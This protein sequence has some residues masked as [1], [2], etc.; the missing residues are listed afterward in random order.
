MNAEMTSITLALRVFATLVFALLVD[1]PVSFAGSIEVVAIRHGESINNILS[2]KKQPITF[3]LEIYKQREAMKKTGSIVHNPVLSTEGRDGA[4][5]LNA[6]LF[7]NNQDRNG[8]LHPTSAKNPV[9]FYV[10]PLNRTIQ[11][12]ALVFKDQLFKAGVN[13]LA[14]PNVTEHRKSV[15]ED[16][17]EKAERPIQ[18]FETELQSVVNKSELPKMETWKNEFVSS[19]RSCCDNKIW[20]PQGSTESEASLSKRIEEFKKQLR[21]LPDNTRV[22]VVSHGTF[23]R[24]LFYGIKELSEKKY[25][26]RNLGILSGKLDKETG[27]WIG[28]PSCF[29]PH[30]N[31][32]ATSKAPDESCFDKIANLEGVE[33]DKG[34]VY[35]VSQLLPVLGSWQNRFLKIVDSEGFKG[36]TWSE[37][38]NGGV[39][40]G[41]AL[42]D[43]ETDECK[44]GI[45]EKYKQDR[46]TACYV[47]KRVHTDEHGVAWDKVS[48]TLEI[49]PIS[50]VKSNEQA[51]QYLRSILNAP[52]S[53]KAGASQEVKV[54]KLGPP[55][56]PN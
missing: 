8:L 49:L 16:G 43:S 50:W 15:S 38:H 32:S 22:I 13:M 47:I 51:T 9:V 56:K 34:P 14:N 6:F 20:W 27:K 39:L 44:K 45:P 48:D 17:F 7:P 41:A 31:H 40:K 4:L 33:I 19:M 12:A 18:L 54:E 10:S 26:L 55:R 25:H 23:L 11:T 35:S 53:P 46:E 1:A 52:T 2:Q 29:V 24:T 36:V 42:I 21:S 28:E 37:K 3:F 30:T 5:A